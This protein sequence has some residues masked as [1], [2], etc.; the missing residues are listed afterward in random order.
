MTHP[1][2]NA[3]DVVSWVFVVLILACL[4]W[5]AYKRS[6][7]RGSLV[8]RWIISAPLIWILLR[9]I[10]SVNL[11][12]PIFVLIP[13]LILAVLWA[14]SIGTMLCKPLTVALDGGDEEAE[15]RP[16]Y[17]IA[18]AK[19]QKGLF[20]EAM[21][22]VRRQLEKFPGDCEGYT[23]LASIQMEDLKDLPAAEAT[24]N[25][26]LGLP[27]R[28]PKEVA[29]ALHLLSDWQLQFGRDAQAAI[30]SLQRIVQ[31]YPDTP[32]A[33]AAEQ[34]IARLGSADETSRVR[35]HS[36]FTVA[37]GR[38]DV[39][40]SKESAAVAAPADPLALAEEYV[41][42]LELHPSDTDTREKLA[43]LYA[44]EFQRLDMASEQLEQ[45][46]ELPAEPPKHVARWLNLL[47]TLHIK[48][49]HDAAAAEGTLRRVMEKFP[50]SAMATM[51]MSRL[52]SL[53]SELKASQ[54]VQTT[55]LGAY[56]KDLGLKQSHE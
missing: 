15:A 5:R 21:A 55:T 40:L 53:Q 46:I 10:H 43:V 2:S 37:P 18:E 17:F 39:G 4:S 28:A 26:F 35:H 14:P 1:W 34:R 23:K 30:G 20:E 19:R 45:L 24:L 11:Y 50:G 51:A 31:L 25:E 13:S 42:Q 41:R 47:A 54:K 6:T 49:A 3:I 27:E 48:V 7:D 8:V 29:G 36:K 52:A 56:E 12:T 9:L 16:F 44:E 33:H 38:R 22:E 32:F